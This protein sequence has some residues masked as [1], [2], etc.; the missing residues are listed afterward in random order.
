MYVYLVC[1]YISL[2]G[3][4]SMIPKRDEDMR[5][6]TRHQMLADLDVAMGGR[7]A[8]ELIFGL[9]EV[10]TGAGSDLQRAT[11]IA[12]N[13][14]LGVGMGPRVGPRSLANTDFDNLS[15]ETKSRVDQ[16]ISELLQQSY[17]RTLKLIT[18]R[19]VYTYI[20]IYVIIIYII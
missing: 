19:K 4:T 5:S 8:E 9:N 18:Q 13:M 17:K 7:V 20:Y 2:S 10:T 1:M 6:R 11:S 16:D 12:R 3:H 14:V 15:A